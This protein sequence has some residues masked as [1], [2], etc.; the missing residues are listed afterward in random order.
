M[1]RIRVGDFVRILRNP[2]APIAEGKVGRVI[3]ILGT[4]P[5]EPVFQV[6]TDDGLHGQFRDELQRVDSPERKN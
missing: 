3:N 5:T 2:V 4:H 1:E 6:E